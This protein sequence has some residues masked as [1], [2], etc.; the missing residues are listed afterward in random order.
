M[1]SQKLLELVMIV[2]N[3]GEILREC[4]QK[5]RRFIDHWTIVDT[6]STDNTPDIIREELRD[7][8]GTLHFSEFTNFSETRNKAFELADKKCKY[9]IVL[10]DSYEIGNGKEMREY[11]QKSNA[12]VINS[13][14]AFKRENVLTD[15][16]YSH[17]ITKS[18][19]GLRYK[20]RVHEILDIPDK[21][22]RKRTQTVDEKTFYIIDH[23]NNEHGSRTQARNKRDIE[24][25]LLDLK[26][27]PK[28][29]RLFYYLAVTSFNL[30]QPDEAVKYLT[31]LLDMTNIKEYT[32]YAEYNL[33]LQNYIKTDDRATYQKK[34]MNL[35]QRYLDR[36][37][38]S[39]KL[40][41][42][43]YEEGQLDKINAIM[44]RLIQ[45]PLPQLSYTIL[46]HHVYEYQI[47]YLY[48]E[49]K[50]KSGL[51]EKGVTVLKDLLAQHPSDQKL[52]NMKY[53][54]CDNLDKGHSRLAPKTLVIHTGEIHFTWNPALPTKI[55]GSEYMAM[56][57]A[58]EFRDLGYRVFIFGQFLDEKDDKKIDYQTTIDGIQY[59]DNVYFSDFC[60][61]YVVD[62]L[63][64]S[65]FIN[66]LVYYDNVK[67]VYLWLHDILP[68]GGDFRFIQIHKEKFKGVICISEWQKRYVMKHTKIDEHVIYVSRNAIH[69]KRFNGPIPV[70]RTPFR[71]VF[72]S[73]PNRGFNNFVE[74]IPWIKERYPQ[75]TFYLFGRL[76]QVSNEDMARA[77]AMSDYVFL[78]PRVSQEQLVTE[79]KKSDV[80]LYPTCFDE[81][82]CIS[83]VEAMAAG[84]LVASINEAALCEIVG[85]RGVMVDYT[86]REETN[87]ALFEALCKVLDDPK[88]KEEITERGHEWAMKQDYYTL[89]LDWKKKLF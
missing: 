50:F 72:T 82:Y 87:R 15:L 66:N 76:E 64:V 31:K 53:A 67:S 38:P 75:S 44:D 78:S 17:R 41:V 4:L 30:V 1:S 2:K 73:D 84:C 36:A 57:I 39:Y 56:N 46:E 70:G 27:Y 33:I 7:I 63:I 6:G 47:P 11:L 20:F 40:A 24:H 89:A 71:F 26:D 10:D 8:P 74:M 14:I 69:P 58:K 83:A 49:V 51:V 54:I 29:P 48:C 18:S 3:S 81:T 28:D 62:Q 52:L 45:V 9:M 59:I 65:R 21:I 80:W 68:M 22:R 25:L 34:L 5:N 60:L 19:S 79:L 86:T 55:S 32:Y 35:Q 43:F 37:E 42:S 12:D 85:D 88:K 13:K 61:T 77:K 23:T 16:Y